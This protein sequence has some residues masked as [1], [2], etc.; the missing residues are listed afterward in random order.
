MSLRLAF[1]LLVVL[2]FAFRFAAACGAP[3]LAMR[4]AWGC[5]LVAALIWALS[6]R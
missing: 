4:L 3:P 2:G 5:W 1:V 6:N